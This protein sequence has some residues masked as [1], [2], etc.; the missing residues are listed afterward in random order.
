MDHFS[1]YAL[2]ES[3]QVTETA[4]SSGKDTSSGGSSSSS[5]SRTRTT[6]SRT[7]G[8]SR[9]SSSQSID[10]D[11]S[12]NHVAAGR[13]IPYT[14]DPMPVKE[15]MG[16]GFFAV[17]ICWELRFLILEGGWD[18][19]NSRKNKNGITRLTDAA[20]YKRGSRSCPGILLVF[21]QKPHKA[22]MLPKCSCCRS[23]RTKGQDERGEMIFMKRI[24]N[25]VCV[26]LAFICIGL[27][28]IGIVLPILPTT[29]LF[30]LAVVLFAKGS[31]RFST[32]GFLSTGLYQKYLAD[33]VA[34]R[35]MTKRTK[36]R[37][38]AF[39]TVLIAI[40]FWFSPV[41]AKVILAVVLLFHYA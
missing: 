23:L 18:P 5:S 32:A 36:I 34:T 19:G 26:A 22:G 13:E 25:G 17:M 41:F 11:S 35:S 27:G 29:P 15:L 20:L 6:S 40:G 33:F 21:R 1:L 4:A 7:S 10:S 37:I 28:C 31:K 2:A 8:S 14:G 12:G 38:L 39:V 24:I 3:N 30:L 16:I 9:T